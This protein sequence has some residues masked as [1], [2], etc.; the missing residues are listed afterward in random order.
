MAT[1]RKRYGRYHVRVRK[2]GYPAVTQTFSSITSDKKWINAV[3][4]DMERRLF[5]PVSDITVGEIVARHEGTIL[6]KHRGASRYQSYRIKRLQV[7]FGHQPVSDLKSSNIAHYQDKRLEA[8]TLATVR[9]ELVYVVRI[10]WT[11]SGL[12]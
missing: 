1:I 11:R 3:E 7:A 5:K 4:S 10:F 6:P 9:R 2:N 8:I 12:N